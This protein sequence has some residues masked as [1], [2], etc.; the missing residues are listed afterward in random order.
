MA[1]ESTAQF[2][3]KISEHLHQLVLDSEDVEVFLRE[4]AGISARTLSS[5]GDEVLCG[6]TLWRHRKPVTVA[7]S[8]EA[9]EK[10]GQIQYRFSD[11]PCMKASREQVTIELPDLEESTDWPVYSELVMDLGIRSLLAVPFKL[12]G[13]TRAALILY[14]GR[15]NRFEGRTRA[16]AEDFVRQTSMA[17]DL[18]VRLARYSEAAADLRA[19]LETRTVIDMAVGIIMAQNRCS[20]IEAFNILKTASSTRNIKLRE[21]AR[22]VVLNLGQGPVK[23]YYDA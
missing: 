3:E 14:S 11:S 21:V 12:E 5:P 9:A 22:T 20:Q 19:T 15:A 10:I 6:V 23:T 4:L 2:E 8:N 17:L 16:I 1:S 18:A 13:D 7:N